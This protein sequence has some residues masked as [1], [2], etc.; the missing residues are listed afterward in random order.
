MSLSTG[1]AGRINLFPDPG[2]KLGTQLTPDVDLGNGQHVV[3]HRHQGRD[4]LDVKDHGLPGLRSRLLE[5]G[6][7]LNEKCFRNGRQHGNAGYGGTKVDAPEKA[8]RERFLGGQLDDL[9]DLLGGDQPVG[10]GPAD[11][12]VVRRCATPSERK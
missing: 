11:D 9:G 4:L 2:G 1:E 7:A 12:L 6:I 8:Q 10:L 5:P 3:G